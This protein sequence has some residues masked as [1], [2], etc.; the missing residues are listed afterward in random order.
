M[1]KKT[2]ISVALVSALAVGI[3]AFAYANNENQASKGN[4]NSNIEEKVAKN[5]KTFEF[6]KK[7]TKYATD[8]TTDVL[9]DNEVKKEDIERVVKHGDHWHVFTKDGREIITYTDPATLGDNDEGGLAFVSVV[10][11]D[12]LKGKNITSIKLHGDHYHVYD[13]NGNEFLTYEDPS[14]LFPNLTIGQYVGSHAPIGGSSSGSSLSAAAAPVRSSDVVRILVHGDH[15]H[16]YTNDGREFISYENPSALYP[17]AEFGVYQ[18]THSNPQN[19]NVT[20]NSPKYVNVSNQGPKVANVVSLDQLEDEVKKAPSSN[21]SNTVPFSEKDI[22]KIAVHEDHYHIYTKDGK[23]HIIYEDPKQYY[24][25]IPIV[26]FEL[27][28]IAGM[29]DKI[30]DKKDGQYIVND[31]RDTYKYNEKDLDL[32][33]RAFAELQLSKVKDNYHYEIVT[34]KNGELEPQR[35]VNNSDLPFHAENATVDTGTSFIIPHIDHI[36][37]AYYDDMSKEQIATVKYLMTHPA[38][39]PAPWVDASHT[40]EDEKTQAAPDFIANVTPKEERK[41]KKNWQIIYSVEEV[42][43]AREEGR[44]ATNDGYIFDPEDIR[45]PNVTIFSFDNSFNIPKAGKDGEFRNIMVSDLSESEQKAAEAIIKERKEAEKKAEEEKENNKKDKKEETSDKAKEDTSKKSSE[46]PSEN[47]T[48]EKE[49]KSD[50]KSSTNKSSDKKEANKKDSD[51]TYSTKESKVSKKARKKDLENAEK[52]IRSE[53]SEVADEK[54]D[55]TSSD[56]DEV[57]NK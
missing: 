52:S 47:K 2:G 22:V 44:Y 42:A 10:S 20:N 31:G 30:V 37:I 35:L 24:P 6:V 32:T 28:Q 19:G 18:G 11:L 26:E 25:N 45:D 1:N 17:N 49:E 53:K 16:I 9:I 15:Y 36:H 40:K 5:D 48:L 43:K 29:I 39:R 7:E 38:E 13:A 23:E 8:K 46:K 41:G 50:K 27:P 4:T 3:G 14:S 21:T 34:P 57:T 33:N 12:Q 54:E 56:R 51:E 55:T